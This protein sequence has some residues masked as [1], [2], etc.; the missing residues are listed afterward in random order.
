[1]VERTGNTFTVTAFGV[2][3]FTLL[4]SPE[5]VDFAQPVQVLVNG[6]GVLA[7]KIEPS[8]QT[9]LQGAARDRDRS[10][11]FAAELPIHVPE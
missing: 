6:T 3:D 11:L 5:E 8:E 1:M 4:L 10:M 9:L 7:R 2:S